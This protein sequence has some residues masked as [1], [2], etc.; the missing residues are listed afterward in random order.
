MCQPIRFAAIKTQN[1]NNIF[2]CGRMHSNYQH[3]L[4]PN[5]I[6][7]ETLNRNERNVFKSNQKR[8]K[9]EQQ[10]NLRQRIFQL[11]C[12]LKDFFFNVSGTGIKMHYGAKI[13]Y[14]SVRRINI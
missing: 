12:S 13:K 6:Q 3:L 5:H 10:P 14:Y 2:G 8:I 4:E 1:P 11:L 9:I 7:R